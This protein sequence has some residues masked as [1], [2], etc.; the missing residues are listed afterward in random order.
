LLC[1]KGATSKDILQIKKLIS[2]TILYNLDEDI[3]QETVS[4]RKN[5]RLKLPDAI[6]A[7]SAQVND[8]VLLTRNVDDFK[9]IKGLKIIN[10]Y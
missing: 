1:W 3:K 4:I 9:N 10:P 7:A 6:I 8:L 2:R 5:Y